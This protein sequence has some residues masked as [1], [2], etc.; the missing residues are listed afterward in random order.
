[1]LVLV[2]DDAWVVVE[3]AVVPLGFSVGVGAFEGWLLGGTLG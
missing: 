1:M 3:E 2:E